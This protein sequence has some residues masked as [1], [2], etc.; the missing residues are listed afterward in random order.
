V[1][2]AAPALPAPGK[3]VVPRWGLGDAAVGL[4]LAV[5]L[6]TLTYS[7]VLGATGRAADDDLPL[8]LTLLATSGLWA[9]FIAVPLVVTHRKG[10]GAVEDLG[11]RARWIDLPVGLVI[12]AV[13]QVALL[14]LYA[15]IFVLFDKSQSD[16]DA[17]ARE[18]GDLVDGPVSAVL[19][20][21]LVV[22][23][24][25]IAEEIFYRGLVLRSLIKR[26][27]PGGLSVVLTALIFA[28]THIQDLATWLLLLPGLVFAGLVFGTLALRT[29]RLGTS[30]AAHMGFNLVTAIALLAS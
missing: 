18:L 11:L 9:A 23:G 29:G 7:L 16:L 22:V 10:R 3:D 21:V 19:L 5:T 14:L 4:L 25:P 8:G 6:S 26:G 13:A 12:G 15:P 1:T 17:P 2:E 28:A 27:L 30:I 24:A 20:L